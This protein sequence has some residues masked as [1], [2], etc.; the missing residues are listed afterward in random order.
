MRCVHAFLLLL[1]LL[2]L[3]L[4]LSVLCV[5]VRVM[6]HLFLSV[7]FLLWPGKLRRRAVV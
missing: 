6:T 2:L 1:L 7:L 3:L 4:M 5:F